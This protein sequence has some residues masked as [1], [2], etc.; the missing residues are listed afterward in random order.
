MLV[1]VVCFAIALLGQASVISGVNALAWAIGGFLA[2]AVDVAVGGY[3]FAI[4]A[5]RGVPPR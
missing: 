4:P 2:W 5:R 1:A 3:M